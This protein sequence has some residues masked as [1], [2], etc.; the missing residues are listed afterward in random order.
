MIQKILNIWSRIETILIGL[1]V[2]GAITV[3]LSGML[4]RIFAPMNAIDWADEV[5]IYCIIW[6]T[7]L[8]GS[9]LASEGRHINAEI[10][11]AALPARAQKV[12]GLVVFALVAGFCIAITIFGWQAYEFANMLDE[13]SATSLRTPQGFA[14]FLALPVG[15]GLI[16]LR[17]VLL[18]FQGRY[19][20]SEGGLPGMDE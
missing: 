2:I 3:F 7:V 15:M 1:L 14:G 17:M 5:A 6:A 10:V 19:T 20:V 11:V 8:S 9:V 13:R 4:I 12:L 16:V 18:A